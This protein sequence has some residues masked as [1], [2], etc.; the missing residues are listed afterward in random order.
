MQLLA[1]DSA[2]PESI[3]TTGRDGLPD[4]PLHI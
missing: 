3:N 2:K 4:A 1:R